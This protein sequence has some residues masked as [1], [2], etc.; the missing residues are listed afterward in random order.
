MVKPAFI[1]HGAQDRSAYYS[2]TTQ[3]IWRHR[4]RCYFAC[5]QSP[6]KSPY[7]SCLC[8]RRRAEKPDTFGAIADAKRALGI[9][10]AQKNPPTTVNP[11]DFI[12]WCKANGI[13]TAWLSSI[14]NAP[15]WQKEIADAWLSLQKAG[16]Q[17]P[18]TVIEEALGKYGKLLQALFSPA[19]VQVDAP[20]HTEGATQT[21][22]ATRAARGLRASACGS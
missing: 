6:E 5:S 7:L 20:T 11:F 13:D 18:P 9:W 8:I 22:N 3:P 12:V 15:Q 10:R 21:L 2:N 14:E 1:E 17:L 19:N 4:A 16:E